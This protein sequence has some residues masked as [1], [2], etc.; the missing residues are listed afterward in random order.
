MA[1]Q[2]TPPS[3]LPGLED[4]AVGHGPAG[5][6]EDAVAASVDAA[7]LPALD[8]GAGALA[9]GLAR[10]VDVG[11]ARRDP[12]AVAQAAGPLREQLMRLRLDPTSRQESAD[13]FAAWLDSLDDDDTAQGRDPA[14]PHA[15]DA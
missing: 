15:E 1:E 13:G 10:A 8:R 12:F 6:V 3:A 14:I 7:N 9:V 2:T 4:P 11:L 5:R